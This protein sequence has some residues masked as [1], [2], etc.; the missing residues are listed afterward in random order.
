MIVTTELRSCACLNFVCHACRKNILVHN[1]IF[2]RVS[3]T[4]SVHV[5]GAALPHLGPE[6]GGGDLQHDGQGGRP[7]VPR[8]R[9]VSHNYYDN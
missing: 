5:H 1:L 6:H 2:E 9:Q 8:H 4:A 3:D 7:H